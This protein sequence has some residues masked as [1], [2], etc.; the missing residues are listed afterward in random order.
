MW[1]A[2]TETAQWSP[3]TLFQKAAVRPLLLLPLSLSH[4]CGFGKH[5]LGAQLYPCSF[6][7]L[8]LLR[9]EYGT[10]RTLPWHPTS[11]AAQA[12]SAFPLV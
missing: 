1:V 10:A 7:I 8:Y 4:L 11:V 2:T 9:K 6:F 12:L 5:L 3:L